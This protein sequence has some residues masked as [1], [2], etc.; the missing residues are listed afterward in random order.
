MLIS[1]EEI[2]RNSHD[3][4][5][6]LEKDEKWNPSVVSLRTNLNISLHVRYL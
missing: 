5:S 6:I 4:T 2:G 3:V 1:I